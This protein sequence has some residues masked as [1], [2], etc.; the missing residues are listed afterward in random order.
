MGTRELTK[1]S[2]DKGMVL[3]PL[4]SNV[5]LGNICAIQAPNRQALIDAINVFANPRFF[6]GTKGRCY[7]HLETHGEQLG[8]EGYSV[9][10]LTEADVPYHSIPCPCGNPKHWLIKYDEETKEE[11]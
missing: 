1:E 9:D 8:C 11:A 3:N 4:D 6:D 7:L 5:E 10:Y 2:Q